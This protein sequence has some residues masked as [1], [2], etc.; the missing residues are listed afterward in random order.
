MSH[1][2]TFLI[3]DDDRVSVMAIERAIRKLRL[4][5]P[6]EVAGDGLEALDRLREGPRD[7]RPYI[8]LLDL[9]MPRM[10]GLEFL[11]N[12]RQDVELRNSVV[13][14]QTTSYAPADIAKAYEHMV[15]GYIV[16]DNTFESMRR[17]MEMLGAYTRIVRLPGERRPPYVTAA[18]AL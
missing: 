14:V 17:A 3:V 4:D 10:G 11:S 6:I 9:H 16:K 5:N 8:I 12:V 18:R 1:D 7:L 13:F 2:V 15:A